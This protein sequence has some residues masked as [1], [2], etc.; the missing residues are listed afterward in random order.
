MGNPI[1]LTLTSVLIL[2]LAACGAEDATPATDDLDVSEV[3]GEWVVTSSDP[4][5]ALLWHSQPLQTG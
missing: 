4:N 3:G 2:L 5:A 1:L